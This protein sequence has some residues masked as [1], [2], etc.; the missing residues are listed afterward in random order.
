MQVENVLLEDPNEDEEVDVP[1]DG[2]E[3]DLEEESAS[4]EQSP[5][6]SVKE[7]DSIT[8]RLKEINDAKSASLSGDAGLSTQSSSIEDNS[9][10]ESEEDSSIEL[11]TLFDKAD[12]SHPSF[13]GASASQDQAFQDFKSYLNYHCNIQR[14]DIPYTHDLVNSSGDYDQYYI[15]KL[16]TWVRQK[17]AEGKISSYDED[18]LFKYLRRM[19]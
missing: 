12:K 5:S 9:S 18:E 6:D 10:V 3:E 17:H 19:K 14:Y 11:E 2:G 4:L 15:S 1:M 16:E 13:V 8:E 7:S